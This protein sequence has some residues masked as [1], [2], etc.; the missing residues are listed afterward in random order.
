[1]NNKLIAEFLGWDVNNP[2]TFPTELHQEEELQ[3]FW[4][5]KF[6]T[7]WN[8]LIKAVEKIEHTTINN[9]TFDFFITKEK[10]HIHYSKNNDWFSNLFLHEGNT[11][12]ENTYNAVVEFIEFYNKLK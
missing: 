12:I 7:D 9:I 8:W 5:L 3:G 2:S 1:M 11:K 10:T 4:E 6:D